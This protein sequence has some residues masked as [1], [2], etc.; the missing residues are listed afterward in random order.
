MLRQE[1]KCYCTTIFVLFI[2]E[3]NFRT[4]DDHLLYNILYLSQCLLKQMLIL[5]K[6]TYSVCAYNSKREPKS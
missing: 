4:F 1:T 6:A 5:G 3:N 2:K